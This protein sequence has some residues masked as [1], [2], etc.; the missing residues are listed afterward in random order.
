MPGRKYQ[1]GSGFYRYGFNGKEKDNDVKGE[2]NQQDYGMRIYDPRLGK[3]L[4]VD[5]LALKFPELTPYQFASNRPIDGVD[6]D[7]LEWW[8]KY[9]W[10]ISPTVGIISDKE[11]MQG[12]KDRGRT[13]LKGFK[14]AITNVDLSQLHTTIADPR[15]PASNPKASMD[16]LAAA[17]TAAYNDYTQLFGRALKGDKNAVGGV[18]FETILLFTP[19]AEEIG[20]AIKGLSNA[21]KFSKC[22]EFAAEFTTKIEPM[23]AK[24][25]AKVQTFEIRIV[26]DG[27]PTGAYIATTSQGVSTSGMHRFVQ[28]TTKDGVEMVFDNMH[29]GGMLKSEYI[30]EIATRVER[31]HRIISGKEIFEKMVKEIPKKIPRKK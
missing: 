16:Q 1:V 9:V 10:L 25:G 24:I 15:L 7:G 21:G 6:I 18:I 29:P 17:A 4:S 2:G 26:E 19:G 13:T 20:G 22:V 30:K 11:I 8:K 14:E 31:T 28:V 23:F 12:I 3:F 5:P 27:A